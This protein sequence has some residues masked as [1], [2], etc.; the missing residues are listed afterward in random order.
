MDMSAAALASIF[1]DVSNSAALESIVVGELPATSPR[2]VDSLLASFGLLGTT[3]DAKA[4]AEYF[5]KNEY[6]EEEKERG[7]CWW[8]EYCCGEDSGGGSGKKSMLFRGQQRRLSLAEIE[9]YESHVAAAEEVDED[10]FGN[11]S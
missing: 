9:L 2:E 6:S 1:A 5:Y 4:V 8:W 11:F 7:A 10:F 3:Y